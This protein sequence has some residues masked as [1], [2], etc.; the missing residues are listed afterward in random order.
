MG[1]NCRSILILAI[2]LLVVFTSVYTP[3]GRSFTRKKPLLSTGKGGFLFVSALGR[4]A[5]T[6]L[7]CGVESAKILLGELEFERECLYE[8]GI[9]LF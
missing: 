2:I 6:A 9:Y 8:A 3:F 7:K 4:M 5:G 1:C